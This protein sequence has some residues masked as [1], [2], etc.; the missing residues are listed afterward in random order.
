MG[1]YVCKASSEVGLAVTKGK[2]D[3]KGNCLLR[4]R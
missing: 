4:K 3:V 1:T 2:L